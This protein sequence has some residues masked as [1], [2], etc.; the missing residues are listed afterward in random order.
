M[1][2][3]PAFELPYPG[4]GSP[5]NVPADLY[6]L[7]GRLEELLPTSGTYE[8]TLTLVDRAASATTPAPWLWSR[9]GDIVTVDGQIQITPSTTGQVSVDASL[10]VP[11]NLAANGDL[12]GVMG[13]G[14]SSAT[15]G[16]VVAYSIQDRARLQFV[17]ASTTAVYF[18]VHFAYRVI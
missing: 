17:A 1:P 12:S 6:A 11:S 2:T 7:A 18:G 14:V 8:P 15:A 4:P 3:T 10:P 9:I 16:L 5:D 13:S